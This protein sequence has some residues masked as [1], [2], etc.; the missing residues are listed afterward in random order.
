MLDRDV[1]LGVNAAPVTAGDSVDA[2]APQVDD[3]GA[4]RIQLRDRNTGEHPLTDLSLQCDGA[5]RAS[6]GQLEGGRAG[7][8]GV[9]FADR[10][11]RIS[12]RQVFDLQTVLDRMD[13]Q[14]GHA[15]L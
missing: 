5:C 2:P 7:Q 13:E 10:A 14:L 4:H 3:V 11:H 8:V 6:I 15:D 12:E 1:E 9:N